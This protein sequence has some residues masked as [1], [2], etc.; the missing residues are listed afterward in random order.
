MVFWTVAIRQCRTVI[1][2]R[3]ETNKINIMFAPDY[4]LKS[5]FRS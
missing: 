1:P 3:E 5:I 4:Y 2:Q